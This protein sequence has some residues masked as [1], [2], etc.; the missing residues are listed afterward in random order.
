MMSR[1]ILLVTLLLLDVSVC[2]ADRQWQTG[3]CVGVET[4]RKTVDFGPGASPFG[5]G[6]VPALRALADVRTYSIEN[7]DLRLELE[8]VVPVG[9]RSVEMSAGSSV[10]FALEKNTVYLREVDGKEYR[11]RVTKKTLKIAK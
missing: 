8:D 5:S 11:L 2:A 1:T 7:D 6:S 4:K 9:K 3:I 10:T